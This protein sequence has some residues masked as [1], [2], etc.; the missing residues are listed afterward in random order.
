MAFLDFGLFK[1]MDPAAVELELAAQ[2]AVVEQDAAALHELLADSG[3]LPEPERVNP[4]HLLAFVE[5]AIWWYTT[6]DEEVQLTPAI[7]THVCSRAPTRARVTSA[8][9]AIRTCARSTCSGGAWRC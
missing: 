5:D 1:R 6:A 7:A 9:C 2:R 4:E 8:R 3:F